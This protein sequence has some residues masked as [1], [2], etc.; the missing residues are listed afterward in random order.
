ML[1]VRWIAGHKG[2][3]GNETADEDVM[4]AALGLSSDKPFLPQEIPAN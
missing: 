2:T 4:K 1:T 3:P